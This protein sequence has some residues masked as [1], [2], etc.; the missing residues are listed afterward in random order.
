M[1]TKCIDNL[2]TDKFLIECYEEVAYKDTSWQYESTTDRYQYPDDCVFT[3]GSSR[4]M[5]TTWY[6]KI[7]DH[8]YM[9]KLPPSLMYVY[10]VILKHFAEDLPSTKL[11]RIQGNL[12][13]EGMVQTPHL[14]LFTNTETER[15]VLFFPHYK[16]E[17]EWGG[18]FVTYDSDNNIEGKY[19]PLPGRLL[20]IDNKI[21][22]HGTPPIMSQIARYSVVYR[23]E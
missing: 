3:Q 10:E 6:E 9:N 14:D 5:G 7:T 22:H 23:F 19:L 4:F 2:F 21:K 13:V 18:E 17:K 1:K 15:T 11:W 16:W 12:Q 8:F 20:L